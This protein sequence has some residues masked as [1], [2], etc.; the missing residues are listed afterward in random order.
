MALRVKAQKK[1]LIATVSV[2]MYSLNFMLSLNEH[3]KSFI[4]FGPEEACCRCC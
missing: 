4:N 3:E 1:P 2:F